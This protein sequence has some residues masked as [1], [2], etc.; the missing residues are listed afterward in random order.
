MTFPARMHA[1]DVGADV[2]IDLPKPAGIILRPDL[3]YDVHVQQKLDLY[4]PAGRPAHP[5][6]VIVYLHGGGWHRGSKDD[7][8]RLAFHF[9]A[10]GY[11]VA[12][13]DY[14]LSSD[15][16]YPAQLEDSKSAVR[17]LRDNAGRYGLDPDH[18]GVVGVSAGGHL[19]ALM[20]ALNSNRLYESG[21][22]LDQPSRVQAVC[23]F[24]GPVDLLQLYETSKVL[25]TPQADEI[26]QL[27]GGDPHVVETQ[28][29]AANPVL[30]IDAETPPFL[31]IQGDKDTTVPPDQSQLLYDSLVKKHIG[32]HLH[33]I[34]GAG[35]TGP[36][37]VAPDINA[38]VDAFFAL[39]LK[40]GTNP[41]NPDLTSLT[42]SDA[43]KK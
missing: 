12:C 32:A 19:A 27:L 14:R 28:A 43:A 38:M 5:R 6:P 11:A 25:G 10:Q 34:H 31:I 24:F 3:A 16:E 26:A 29:L 1:Q 36:A 35:H 20:G 17:W 23:D 33:I 40:K 41:S 42:E 8:R 22:S 18:I 37:Y 39:T 9:A 15:A 4:L 21:G 2:P 7:G 30:F 13:V